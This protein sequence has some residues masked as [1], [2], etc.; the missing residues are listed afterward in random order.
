MATTLMD[1]VSGLETECADKTPVIG[2]LHTI[3]EYLNGLSSPQFQQP[4]QLYRCTS[5]QNY[6]SSKNLVWSPEIN[7]NFMMLVVDRISKGLPVI[8][9][10]DQIAIS[11]G[12]LIKHLK[13]DDRPSVFACE[14]NYIFNKFR[15]SVT[16]E[17]D[18]ECKAYIIKKSKKTSDDTFTNLLKEALGNIFTTNQTTVC[19]SGYTCAKQ[20]GGK[21][22]RANK[23]RVMGRDR[24]AYKIKVEG[25]NYVRMVRYM[26]KLVF[27]SQLRKQEQKTY[28]NKDYKD[29]L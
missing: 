9:V 15:E 18:S 21:A 28:K 3:N 27:L 8:A 11:N 19:S 23:I 1:C 10:F 16:C 12:E 14:L 7:D 20:D 2:R 25:D 24:V 22:S 5:L 6:C 17:Y 29:Y 26:N 4:R 13:C